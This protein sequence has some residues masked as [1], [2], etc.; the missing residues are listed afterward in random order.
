MNES[1]HTNRY[2]RGCP[3]GAR[4]SSY[5][6]RLYSGAVCCSVLQRVAMCCSVLQCVAACCSALQCVAVCC[7][8]LQ[9]VAVRCNLLQCE[10]ESHQGDETQKTCMRICVAVHCCSALLQCI[11]AVPCAALGSCCSAEQC[12]VAVPSVAIIMK[13]L[14]KFIGLFC[15]RAL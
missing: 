6:A 1:R 15:K 13:R 5:H 9:R 10:D 8:V 2:C 7:S 3:L 14:L 4:R 12:R 11:V